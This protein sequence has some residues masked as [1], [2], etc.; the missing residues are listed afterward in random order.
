MSNSS[1]FMALLV[2][3]L[4]HRL[5]AENKSGVGHSDSDHTLPKLTPQALAQ[6]LPNIEIAC[7]VTIMQYLLTIH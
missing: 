3:G 4:H 2:V 6:A 7:T 5:R 1:L